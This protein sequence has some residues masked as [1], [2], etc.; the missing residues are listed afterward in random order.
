MGIILVR[1]DS[2]LIH[3]QILEA[4]IPF[5]KAEA[6]V[7]ID[8][9]VAKDVLRRSVMEMA[10]PSSIEVKFDTVEEAIEEYKNGRY[11]DKRTIIL[12]SSVHDA[13]RAFDHGFGF[14]SI[15]LGNMH[16][17]EGKVRVSPHLCLGKDDSRCIKAF[18]GNG[19][20][21]DSRSVPTE[22]KVEVSALM[23]SATQERKE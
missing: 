8:D 23:E 1:V 6:I 14:K 9:M 19:V 5:T 18:A 16:Y 21:I 7:V 3:G 2:R 17:C 22:K 12:F 20:S 13:K 15:N 4:W 11:I 10:V